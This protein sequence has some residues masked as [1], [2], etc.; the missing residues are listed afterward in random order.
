MPSVVFTIHSNIEPI[1]FRGLRNLRSRLLIFI[2]F[3]PCSFPIRRSLILKTLVYFMFF[4]LQTDLAFRTCGTSTDG[5][6]DDGGLH[7]TSVRLRSVSFSSSQRTTHFCYLVFSHVYVVLLLC[8]LKL[9]CTVMYIP[10]FL[11]RSASKTHRVSR[12]TLAFLPLC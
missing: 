1:V 3:I 2:F 4:E 7:D 6:C 10:F 8:G 12:K 11:A 9:T 5:P